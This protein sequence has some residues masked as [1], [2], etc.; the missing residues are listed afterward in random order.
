MY[1]IRISVPVGKKPNGELEDIDAILVG[2]G[3][4]RL[5]DPRPCTS[6]AGYVDVTVEGL[7]LDD[8]RVLQKSAHV[9]LVMS[10]KGS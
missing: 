8:V 1:K 5:G 7:T 3:R 2:C 4:R 10:Y 9:M 6:Y